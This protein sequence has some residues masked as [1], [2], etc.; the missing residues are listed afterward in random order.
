MGTFT[1]ILMAGAAGGVLSVLFA[2]LALKARAEWI[3]AM[4]SYAIGAL[5]GAAFLEILPHAIEHAGS[6]Q[7][8]S[9]VILGGILLFFLLEKLVLWRHCHMETCEAHGTEADAGG[10][11]HGHA[12]T[13]GRAGMMI[14][15]GDT[16]HNFV[17]GVLI[18][19][20]FLVDVKLGVVTSIAIIAH[21]IPQ[22]M[23][24]FIILLHSGYS[25]AQALAINLLASLATLVGATLGYFALAPMQEL[26]PYML[27]LAASSMIYVAVADLIPG[28]HKRPELRH[29]GL[30]IALILLGMLTVHYSAA[31]AEGW[32]AGAGVELHGHDHAEHGH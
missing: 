18:A 4:V 12:H 11:D 32:L 28:L 23:G 15:I 9:A 5:L 31:Y 16:F 20:A 17:D 2:A 14:T 6:F 3:P 30:Q 27:A 13:H 1:W 29:T 21:E 26:M 19:A 10:H 22:E 8:V 24:D 25:R 7:D